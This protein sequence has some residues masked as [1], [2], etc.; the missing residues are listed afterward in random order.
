MPIDSV[1]NTRFSNFKAVI[2]MRSMDSSFPAAM[3]LICRPDPAT[4]IIDE[5]LTRFNRMR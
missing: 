5:G 4:L 3:L 2:G 1:S